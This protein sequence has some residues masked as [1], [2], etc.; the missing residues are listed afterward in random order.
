MER[1][2]RVI[3]VNGSR[4]HAIKERDRRQSYGRWKDWGERMKGKEVAERQR[5][6]PAVQRRQ[7]MKQGTQ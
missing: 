6:R 7:R 2:R 5:I 4:E 1:E 3:R